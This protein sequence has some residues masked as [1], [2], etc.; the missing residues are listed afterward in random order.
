M[1]NYHSESDIVLQSNAHKPGEGIFEIGE[2]LA[3]LESPHSP[4]TFVLKDAEL[5]RKVK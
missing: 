1:Q 4:D 3:K 5:T 2:H